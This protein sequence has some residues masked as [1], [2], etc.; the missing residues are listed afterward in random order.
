MKIFLGIYVAVSM[1]IAVRFIY[2]LLTK[3]EVPSQ[4]C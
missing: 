1:I 2:I 3:E 4:D